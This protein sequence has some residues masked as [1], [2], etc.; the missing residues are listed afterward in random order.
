MAKF[1][2]AGAGDAFS[3][4][5]KSTVEAPAWLHRQG[6]DLLEYQCGRGVRIG[7]ETAEKIG[8]QAAEH[9][10]LMSVHAPYF[11]NLSSDEP[12]RRQKNEDYV[13]QSCQAAQWLGADRIVVHCGG[14]SG[15]TR[16]QALE[17]SIQGLA[18]ILQAMEDKGFG[19]LCLCVETMGKQNVMGSLEEVAA[20]C[21]SDRRLTPCVDFGHLNARGQGCLQTAEDYLRVLDYL[22]SALGRPRI[23]RFHAHFSHI[24]YGKAGETRHLTFEDEQ[25]GPDFSPCAQA[26]AERDLHPRIVCESAG[27]QAEDALAMKQIYREALE[28]K[29]GAGPTK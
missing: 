15:R 20:I 22:E 2:P 28:Q 11:I 19:G 7:R 9:G 21:Q 26:L 17:N 5:H 24:E 29:G 18:S 14:L 16:A 6:L 12:E 23:E 10:I 1:G 13:L 25:Y 4:C 8:A 3:R 27:T